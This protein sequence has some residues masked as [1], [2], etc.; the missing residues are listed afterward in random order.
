MISANDLRPGRAFKMDGGLWKVTEYAHV[1]P[2]KGP[3]FVRVKLFNIQT[4]SNVEMTLKPELKFEELRVDSRPATYLY[5]DGN[6]YV[7]M[8]AVSFEQSSLTAEFVGKQR[9][10]L[11]ENMEVQLVHAD[12]RIIDVILP[13]HI[14]AEITYTEPGIK[15]DTATGGTK[16]ATIV[17]G[18]TINVPLFINQ[19]DKIKVDT[20]EGKYLERVR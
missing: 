6:Y 14:V 2:G 19:G 11:S 17:G 12:G 4:G 8:D 16:P 15:G 5:H 10:F 3:A 20:R 9:E 13:T 18:A 7:F 1:K